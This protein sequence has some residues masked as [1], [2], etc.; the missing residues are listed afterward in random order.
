[1]LNTDEE[2]NG[3][4]LDNQLTGEINSNTL[5]GEVNGEVIYQE[6]KNHD[7]LQHLDFESSGHTGFQPL[8]ATYV[9]TDNNYTDLDKRRVAGFV[10]EQG[11]AS[12]TWVIL[13]NLEKYPNVSV[14]DSGGTVVIGDVNYDSNNQITITFNG[15]F[16][17]KAIL[18]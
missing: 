3:E 11:I 9:H 8:D 1:M 15:S 7:L 13:H 5:T 18:S 10:Y 16:S 14:V 17:G 2:L 6:V 4:I 12:D